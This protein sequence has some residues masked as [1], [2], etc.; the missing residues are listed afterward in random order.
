MLIVLVM[1]QEGERKSQIK[2]GGGGK[3][4]VSLGLV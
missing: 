2:T 1:D 3:W 4:T